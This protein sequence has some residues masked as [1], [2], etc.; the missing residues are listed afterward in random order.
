[1]RHVSRNTNLQKTLSIRRDRGMI[2][3]TTPRKIRGQAVNDSD[4]NQ[5]KG[6]NFFCE[7]KIHRKANR[8]R[9]A[10]RS[11]LNLHS[12]RLSVI[13][14]LHR[15]RGTIAITNGIL[16]HT[17]GNLNPHR[18][19]P[20]RRDSNDIIL[21]LPIK[22]VNR[23]IAEDNFLLH[24]I[25]HRFRKHNLNIK[26]FNFRNSLRRTRDLHSRTN[27]VISNLRCPRGDVAMTLEVLC[28]VSRNTNLHI[29]P[30]IRRNHGFKITAFIPRKFRGASI[31]KSDVLFSKA[32]NSLG[33]NKLHELAFIRKDCRN[34]PKLHARRALVIINLNR[35]RLIFIAS[36]IPHD[37]RKNR[38]LYGINCFRLNLDSIDII[39]PRHL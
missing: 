17:C 9:H 8:G 12:R 32:R 4:V 20:I 22:V 10:I 36:S 18:P 24:K 1:M 39:S 27:V 15:R 37:A 28:Y 33:E 29:S 21:T 16:H 35:Q 38:N 26:V 34:T 5:L 13:L 2:G 14:H 30:A 19:L 6:L 25:L 3:S 31:H 7:N 23:G 11:F